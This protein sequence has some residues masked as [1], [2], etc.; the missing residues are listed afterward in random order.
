V[1]VQLVYRP[2][3]E[4][5]A[6]VVARE[7]DIG[8]IIPP[9]HSPMLRYTP[10]VSEELLLCVWRGHPL[11]RRRRLT[12]A[13]LADAGFVQLPKRKR[14]ALVAVVQHVCEQAGFAPRV[15]SEA[16]SVEAM[17]IAVANR[18]GIAFTGARHLLAPPRG[19][20][21]RRLEEAPQLTFGAITR[22]DLDGTTA[23]HVA[24]F[25]R[26]VRSRLRQ[27]ETLATVAEEQS[28]GHL[29]TIGIS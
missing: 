25:L 7:V 14:P 1:E 5:E 29:D 6:A 24:A 27:L 8:I 11:A 16:T 20:V 28:S 9:V 4:Q 15:V 23:D 17:H 2:P 3:S 13:E 18:L 12:L 19:V 10:L 22:R 21:L 26:A